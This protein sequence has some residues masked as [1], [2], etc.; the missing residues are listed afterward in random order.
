MEFCDENIHETNGYNLYEHEKEYRL[1]DICKYI[2]T[3]DIFRGT[4]VDRNQFDAK[5]ERVCRL[6][7]PVDTFPAPTSNA[8]R[9]PGRYPTYYGTRAA[10]HE[11]DECS[12]ECIDS[13]GE[14][15]SFGLLKSYIELSSELEC[16]PVRCSG[17]SKKDHYKIFTCSTK[18]S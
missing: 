14:I 1:L 13:V 11:A 3:S 9:P 18:Q 15:Y 10:I 6:Y 8:R 2:G 16:S 12:S 7:F 5:E 17:G 4:T